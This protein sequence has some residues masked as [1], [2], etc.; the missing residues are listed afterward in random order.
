MPVR[1]WQLVTIACLLFVLQGLP[2][3]RLGTAQTAESTEFAVTL[4]PK[5]ESETVDGR[6]FVFFSE[7]NQR[8]T[9]GDD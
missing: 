8:D 7:R 1:L 6:L 2:S 5:I 4:D 9:T 3:H